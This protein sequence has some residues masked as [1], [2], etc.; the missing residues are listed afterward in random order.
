M[1]LSGE[2]RCDISVCGIYDPRFDSHVMIMFRFYVIMIMG[3]SRAYGHSAAVFS[4][5]M[6]DGC[7]DADPQRI[8]KPTL[9]FPQ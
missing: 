9:Y 8:V 3:I 4:K 5:K 1:Y 6:H 7:K 2:M